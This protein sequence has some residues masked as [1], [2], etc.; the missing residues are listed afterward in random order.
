V[1]SETSLVIAYRTRYRGA[2]TLNAI[3]WENQRE[4]GDWAGLVAAHSLAHTV[5]GRYM[6]KKEF[7]V[8]NQ[9]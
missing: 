8:V 7:G 9:F 6:A 3:P 1:V 2:E 4:P 5:S